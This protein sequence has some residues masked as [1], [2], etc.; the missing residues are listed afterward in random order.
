[1]TTSDFKTMVSRYQDD[2]DI[3]IITEILTHVQQETKP[4]QGVHSTFIASKINR[5]CKSN[6]ESLGYESSA[7]LDYRK[8]LLS[9][10]GIDIFAEAD[11]KVI[12]DHSGE[13]K[14]Y[15][16]EDEYEGLCFAI[17][18]YIDF[19]EFRKSVITPALEYSLIRVD[20]ERSEL[21][22]VSYIN[23]AFYTE[24]IHLL[25]KYSGT[26]RLGRSD[27]DGK[28]RNLYVTPAR[29]DAWDIV[30]DRHVEEGEVSELLGRLT[31]KQR[32][33]A[34]KAYEVTIRDIERG[35]MGGYR[36]GERGEYRL[37]FRYIAE[38]LRVEESNLRKTFGKI[39]LRT[40]GNV[41]TIAY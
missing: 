17:E 21:E 30:F 3:T 8:G 16:G 24:Y 37:K 15:L 40:A 13:I 27:K 32:S 4:I 12:L 9:D 28:F 19:F 18:A 20:A 1:M 38:K 6:V 33:Y 29:P 35:E 34:L 5:I 39:R 26:V 7:L 22:I 11:F 31:K 14:A 36:I 23:R 41:P 25:T 10:L 2:G